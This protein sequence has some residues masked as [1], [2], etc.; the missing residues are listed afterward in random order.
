MLPGPNCRESGKLE[1]P[2]DVVS[3][4]AG[5]YNESTVTDVEGLQLMKGNDDDDQDGDEDQDE[6]EATEFGEK[7][8]V[9]T[10]GIDDVI[11][12]RRVISSH[13]SG[14]EMDEIENLNERLVGLDNGCF[15]GEVG[16]LK[17]SGI[18]TPTMSTRELLI[19]GDFTDRTGDKNDGTA[20]FYGIMT[21]VKK[22]D[23]PE[24][25]EEYDRSTIVI[26]QAEDAMYGQDMER[27]G[28][29]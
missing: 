21:F 27:T 8:E 7:D 14:T 3:R 1:A 25:P 9:I 5:E 19:G 15:C 18:A 4:L 23:S 20:G 6:D 22:R 13:R 11:D 17:D 28:V 26:E 16:Y 29:G 10:E 24:V 2:V 12:G